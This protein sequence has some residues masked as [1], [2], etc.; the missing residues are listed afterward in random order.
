MFHR[1]SFKQL[2]AFYWVAHLGSFSAAA[3]RL[4]TTQPSISVRIRDMEQALQLRLFDRQGRLPSLTAKARELVDHVERIIAMG[5]AFD[6]LLDRGDCISGLV[7]VG[8]A[9]TVALTWLPALMTELDRRYPG[10]NVEL[11]IDLSINLRQRLHNGDLDVAFLVGGVN[12]PEFETHVLG[13]VEQR[14]MCSPTLDLPAGEL[15]GQD[16]AAW[17][18][19]THSRGSDHY[20][21]MRRWFDAEMAR[22]ER[23]HGCSSLAT[24]VAMTV[25]GLGL[26][27]LPRAMLKNEIRSGRLKVVHTTRSMADYEFV[28]SYQSHPG[29]RAVSVVAELARDIAARDPAFVPAGPIDPIAKSTPPSRAKR[30]GKLHGAISPGVPIQKFAGEFPD[31]SPF[32]SPGD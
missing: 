26:S 8:A 21:T 14:W 10:I 5:E 7:R 25:A 30:T 24:M 32:E 29:R 4:N 13:R 16:L 15:T 22:P 28:E 11:I 12:R 23:L 19:L 1:I 9:D 31:Q 6:R 3:K 20:Y 18:I 27:V 2:E 17:P